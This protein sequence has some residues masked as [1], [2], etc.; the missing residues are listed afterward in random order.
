MRH[1]YGCHKA[2][3]LGSVSVNLERKVTGESTVPKNHLNYENFDKIVS[4]ALNFGLVDCCAFGRFS[5]ECQ[6]HQ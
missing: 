2:S 1:M 4:N 5:N 6:K 3:D